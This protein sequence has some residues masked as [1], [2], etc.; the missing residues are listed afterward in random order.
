MSGR[1]HL[2]YIPAS[3]RVQDP[4]TQVLLGYSCRTEEEARNAGSTGDCTK[5]GE[6]TCRYQSKMRCS[7]RAGTGRRELAGRRSS[8]R[9]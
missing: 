7:C 8:R 4:V 5:A 9:G 2:S 3:H 6:L 1:E